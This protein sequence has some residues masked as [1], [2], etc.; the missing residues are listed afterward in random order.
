MI[1]KKEIEHIAK[2]ARLGLSDAEIKKYKND[3][4]SILGYIEKLKEVDIS[5]IEP[6]SHSVIVESVT[7]E[8][9]AKAEESEVVRKLAEMAPDKKNGYVKV[10]SVL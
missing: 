3:L 7:R 6:T 1:S 9:E 5:G 8:D 10:K 4:S 2:L